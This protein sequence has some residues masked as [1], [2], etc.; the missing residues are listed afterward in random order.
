MLILCNVS[1][2]LHNHA[3]PD[4]ANALAMNL[5]APFNVWRRLEKSL[6]VWGEKFNKKQNMNPE[7]LNSGGIM[8]NRLTA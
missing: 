6:R 7:W 2:L 1:D 8:K 5:S 4:L 3:P